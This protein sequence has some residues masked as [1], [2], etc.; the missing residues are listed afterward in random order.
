MP[1][2]VVRL[3]RQFQPAKYQLILSIDPKAMTFTGSVIVDGVKTG[4]PSK[5][6]VFHQKNLKI[7]NAKISRL[8][9]SGKREISLSRINL[10]KS[11]TEVRLHTNEVV[12][13]GHYQVEMA[14]SGR[15]T[16]AMHGIYPCYF[17]K[18]RK[19]LIATQFE[20]HHAREAFPCID[21]P[22][23]K[24]VFEL[25]LETPK[26][27]VIGNTP[28]RKQRT[29]DGR[30][31]TEFEAS[32]KMSSYL[33][34]FAFGE[35]KYKEAKT[36][37]GITVRTYATPGNHQLLDFALD[38]AT[39]CVDFFEDYFQT[40]YPLAKLDLVGLPDFSSGAMENW[41]LIT[42]RES[43]FLVDPKTTAIETKQTAA[44]VIAHEIAHQ[45]FG[46][47]VTMR[48]WDDLWLNE[49]F[50]NLMEYIA[51]DG[52]FPKWRIF[53]HFVGGEMA[54]LYMTRNLIGDESFRRG[55][56][57]Y[58]Q[59]HH[60][61]ST[62]AN[63]LWQALS[64]T[65]KMDINNFVDNWLNRPGFPVVEINYQPGANKF[66]ATQQRLVASKQTKASDTI[67]QIPLVPASGERLILKDKR[68][69]FKLSQNLAPLIFND[70]AQ[71]YYQP[72]YRNRQHL[73]SIIEATG[74]QSLSIV[75]RLQLIN[76]YSLMEKALLVQ[77][78][79]NLQLLRAYKN[80][81]EEPVWNAMAGVIGDAKRL[82]IGQKPHEQHLNQFTAALVEKLIK[83][84]GWDGRRTDSVQTQRL[85]NLVLSLGAAAEM[86]TVLAEAKKRFARFKKPSDLAADIRDVIYY[87][88]ARFGTPTDFNKLLKT[89]KELENADERNELA[90]ALTA[91]RNNSQISTL[92][93]ML[94]GDDVRRQD[95]ANWFIWLLRSHYARDET[96]HWLVKN[97]AWIEKN[98][99]SDKSYDD[100]AK[101]SAAVF[102][103]PE[104]LAEYKKFFTPKLRELAL[105]LAIRLGIEEIDSQV[106]WRQKNETTT[107]TWLANWAK[108]R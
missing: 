42:F 54:V 27:A 28:V 5:R 99:A 84:L 66:S 58:F 73:D 91:T 103:R 50:A 39:R 100:F 31:K 86:P 81:V 23:A 26:A 49:S 77:N 75:N 32:P 45:W 104:E 62:E 97:W 38:T 85:R 95:T 41:G 55:L 35:L 33:L 16:D 67:W 98:F 70:E 82:V 44:L 36:K 63:N 108:D 2:K 25:T 46:N 22:E 40:S 14:F 96:W 59:K 83:Q 93:A 87:V 92:V 90:V 10:H 6:L 30:Q 56:K 12:Y 13:P 9:K 78:S 102:S 18:R 79:D 88:A 65:A 69:E 19:I 71:S 52:L 60:Y 8:D 21:E 94:T 53:E 29:E 64:Q 76:G 1:K 43:I 107:K 105:E 74:E 48:W 24:A 4:P 106:A 72:W 3:Y 51:V 80:E 17:D 37:N 57:I 34:A 101:Y 7:K 11:Y 68:A 47:L 61:G 20:S 15:I 89:Y